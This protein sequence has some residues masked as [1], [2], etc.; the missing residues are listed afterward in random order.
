[1]VKDNNNNYLAIA[2]KHLLTALLI[3]IIGSWC[4]QLLY[5]GNCW[6]IYKYS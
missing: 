5:P 2:F 1:M 4:F 3:A 6:Y